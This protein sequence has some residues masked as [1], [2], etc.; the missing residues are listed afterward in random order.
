MPGQNPLP[1]KFP[2]QLSQSDNDKIYII[3]ARKGV[4]PGAWVRFVL[5]LAIKT[6]LQEMQES[7]LVGK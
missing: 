5:R 3:A 4:K 7:E 1:C 2:V 6:E